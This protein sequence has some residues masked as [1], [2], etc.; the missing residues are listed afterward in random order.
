MFNT[1]TAVHLRTKQLSSQEPAQISAMGAL[2]SAV[3]IPVIA[4]G[5]MYT[6]AD[7]RSVMQL[8]PRGAAGVMLGRP[9]LLNPSLLRHLRHSQGG[10]AQAQHVNSDVSLGHDS[11]S[12]DAKTNTTNN[13]DNDIKIIDHTRHIHNTQ[14]SVESVSEEEQPQNQPAGCKD[15]TVAVF[16][17]DFLDLDAHCLPIRT[18][19]RDFLL[20]CIRFEPPFQVCV[21]PLTLLS[22]RVGI[23]C[24]MLSYISCGYMH[25]LVIVCRLSSTLSR[26]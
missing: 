6:C 10:Y 24:D 2:A 9:V 12:D 21:C 22:R 4:N 13:N 14:N 1:H 23:S 16:N 5:D 18:V 25:I 3:S 20:E 19:I 17:N 8:S 26:R 11:N 7:M 15:A